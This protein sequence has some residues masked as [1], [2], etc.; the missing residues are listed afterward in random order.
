M[1]QQLGGDTGLMV[2]AMFYREVMRDL[3]LFHRLAEQASNAK[4]V[5]CESVHKAALG[6]GERKTINC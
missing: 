3:S 6:D 4:C 2:Q 1:S 5:A